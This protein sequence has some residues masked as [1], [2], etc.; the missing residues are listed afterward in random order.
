MQI[1]SLE[2][3]ALGFAYRQDDEL[4]R[5]R[6]LY[7]LVRY[8]MLV[9]IGPPLTKLAVKIGGLPKKLLKELL[10]NQFLGGEKLEDLSPLVK[11]L[12]TYKI[13]IM[14]DY[15]AEALPS[16]TQYEEVAQE[17]QKQI[18]WAK[19]HPNIP[20]IAIKFTSLGPFSLLQKQSEN[21]PFSAREKEAWDRFT[22]RIY[23]LA[24]QAAQNNLALLIDAEESW[25][26]NAIDAL[27][28][29]LMQDF[30]AQ[31]PYVYTTLQ[32]YRHDRLA[33]FEQLRQRFQGKIL[34][35]KLVRGAYVEKENKR[36]HLYHY[37]TPIQPTKSATDKDYNAALLIGLQNLDRIS[38]CI[39]THNL[40][41]CYKTVTF[42]EENQIPPSHPHVYFSQL[43]G[44]SDPI[45]FSLAQAGYNV[46][47]YL[48]YGPLDRA[49]GYLLRRAQE[50]SSIQDQSGRELFWIQKELRRRKG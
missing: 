8:P 20:F 18:Y 7:K 39:A 22:R 47:K 6:I 25:I 19:N 43:Y 34:A 9:K 3:T 13:Q 42:M 49:L 11:K 37:P 45:S 23:T 15:A 1:E 38:L 10:A 46:A 32:M 24:Q 21:V 41:S 17:I 50:N 14:L 29:K 31:K 48:P 12:A 33:Y 5:A 16:E 27:A 30:N 40:I 35:I 2:D 36:A 4:R 28:E 44:M 26:Q